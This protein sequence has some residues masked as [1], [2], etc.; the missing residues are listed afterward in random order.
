MVLRLYESIA[1]YAIDS[2]EEKL[3]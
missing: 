1:A 3:H 2:L